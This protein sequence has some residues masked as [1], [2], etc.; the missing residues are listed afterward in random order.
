MAFGKLVAYRQARP[1]IVGSVLGKLYVG[2]SLEA[3]NVWDRTGDM[4]WDDLHLSASA[5]VGYDT[6]F[7]PLY[8][9][10]AVG[11]RGHDTIF[12]F[13]GTSFGTTYQGKP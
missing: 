9:G 7:G 11:D 6:L 12:L 8:V 13:L 4:A 10:V 5:F 1:T 3:G 2:G